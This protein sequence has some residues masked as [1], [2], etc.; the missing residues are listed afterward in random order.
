MDCHG[1]INRYLEKSQNCPS[2]ITKYQYINRDK[3]WDVLPAGS[4]KL[5]SLVVDSNFLTLKVEYLLFS[6]TYKHTKSIR[7]IVCM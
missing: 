2:V 4:V 7:V 3:N 5:E 6:K 1:A